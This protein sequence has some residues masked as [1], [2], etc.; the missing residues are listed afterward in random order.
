MQKG[1]R[2][3]DADQGAP[4]ERP[5]QVREAQQ[6]E[7]VDHREIGRRLDLFH[8]QEEAAGQVFWHANGW[9]LFRLVESRVRAEMEAAGYLEIRTPQLLRA[10][11]WQ[12]SGHWQA[13]DE[14]MVRVGEQRAL[15]PVSC[16]GAL[17][18]F[19]RGSRSF[20]DLPLRYFELG[21]VFREEPSGALNGLFRLKAFTQ[22]DGHVLLA[23]D[24][25]EEEVARFC[26]L[27]ERL[28][29]AFGFSVGR[30]CLSTRPERRIGS[31]AEWDVAEAGLAAAAAAAGL[32]VELLPGEGAL[33]GPKLEF[34]LSDSRGREWQ[35][36]TVQLDL[37][38]PRRFDLHYVDDQG[39]R[40]VPCLLHHAVLGSLERFIAL[41]LEQCGGRLPLWLAPVQTVVAN[42]GGAERDAAR[43]AVR[44]LT[45]AGLRVR[46]DLRAAPLGRKVHDA[47]RSGIPAF[48]AIGP[49]EA[50]AGEAVLDLHRE[51][52][53]RLNLADLAKCLAQQ[54]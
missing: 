26:R 8:Q 23:L 22:D 33:Y 46:A 43:T 42:V 30:V 7:G 4:R 51:R 2:E 47:H 36:G 18:V 29:S 24:Q 40:A 3:I 5:P 38:M 48:V 45:E 52:K 14:G 28:W 15:K 54:S 19:A 31:E 50:A 37:Q 53:G 12:R 21:Q 27:L 44:Y 34:A 1:S 16:P 10:E 35:C 39:Q 17:S 20:R 41:L 9:R 13:F 11:I 32:A 25:V 6:P 49:T